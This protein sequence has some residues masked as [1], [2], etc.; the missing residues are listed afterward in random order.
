MSDSSSSSH[1]P[2]EF[3]ADL[4]PRPDSASV[5]KSSSANP[6]T[7]NM[8]YNYN[9]SVPTL[10]N[11]GSAA[12]GSYIERMDVSSE[13]DSDD[14]ADSVS[15]EFRD[16]RRSLSSDYQ[17]EGDDSSSAAPFEEAEKHTPIGLQYQVDLSVINR[18]I[19]EDA[20]IG[21]DVR[22]GTLVW[23]P[24]RA[25]EPTLE[26]FLTSTRLDGEWSFYDQNRAPLSPDH[27]QVAPV[28]IM[29]F[30]LHRH[31]YDTVAATSELDQLGL[32]WHPC[33]P[34]LTHWSQGEIEIFEAAM[35]RVEFK[36]ELNFADIQRA[37]KTKNYHEVVEFYWYWKKALKRRRDLTALLEDDAEETLAGLDRKRKRGDSLDAEVDWELIRSLRPDIAP[38]Q[39]G[40]P[41]NNS[42]D[43]INADELLTP[44]KRRKY[45]GNSFDGGDMPPL[46]AD[47]SS[48]GPA[49]VAGSTS[50][51]ITSSD[52]NASE[53]AAL[54]ACDLREVY[55]MFD[56][57]S[58]GRLPKE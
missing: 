37:V 18:A 38:L 22:G 49:A 7:F 23:D 4:V 35:D 3:Q 50:N 51:I 11:Q 44:P 24:S 21:D 56:V 27:T 13:H 20:E 17:S 9:I 12:F 28:E 55:S 1:S 52:L 54:D 6:E 53:A 43:S 29:M 39:S 26:A 25:D 19:E 58:S 16:D 47:S 32:K 57:E 46:F 36:E 8:Q 30:A 5:F 10:E 34:D 48:N 14:H 41:A 33:R 45:E 2:T 31:N 42:G 15:E 40:N